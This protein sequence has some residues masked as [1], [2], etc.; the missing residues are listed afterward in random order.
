M[1]SNALADPPLRA[2]GKLN[3]GAAVGLGG[4]LHG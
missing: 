2:D 1:V 3:V 4:V